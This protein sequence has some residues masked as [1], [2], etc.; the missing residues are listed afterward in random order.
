MDTSPLKRNLF[1][2]LSPSAYKVADLRLARGRVPLL[3]ACSTLC[4][5]WLLFRA[6]QG[7]PGARQPLQR[8]TTGGAALGPDVFR[9]YHAHGRAPEADLRADGDQRAS[10]C[11]APRRAASAST[12][13]ASPCRAPRCASRRARRDPLAERGAVFPATTRTPR[14]PAPR[15]RP[16]GGCTRATPGTWEETGQ[17][18]V[19]DR[20]KDVLRLAP[21]DEFSPQVHREPAE[22]LALRQGSGGHR[23]GQALPGGA[24]AA[25]TR[26]SV[27]KWAE[28]EKHLLY[29]VPDLSRRG[30]LRPAPGEID[31]VNAAPHGGENPRSC[32]STRSWT[33]TTRS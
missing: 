7:P 11:I 19:I 20:L 6:T 10:P 15:S 5:D 27:G 8:A 23:P 14:R 29:D 1:E 17:L 26:P 12:P 28:K 18:V 25:S 9:F 30:R 4:A 3:V 32:S 24:G 22:V 21:A 16:T 13:W 33:R 2:R 31:R